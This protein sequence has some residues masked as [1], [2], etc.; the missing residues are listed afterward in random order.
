MGM[1]K[2]KL[3]RSTGRKGPFEIAG[4]K[5]VPVLFGSAG[6]APTMF[7]AGTLLHRRIKIDITY[8]Y[9]CSAADVV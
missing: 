4:T 9:C 2:E 8:F 6:S 5:V 1:S 7:G 3:V